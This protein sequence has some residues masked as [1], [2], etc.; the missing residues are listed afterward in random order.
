MYNPGPNYLSAGLA[1][2]PTMYFLYLVV[3]IGVFLAWVF[4]F[5]RGEGYVKLK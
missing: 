1:P 3:Y 4:Y 5:M 2:L